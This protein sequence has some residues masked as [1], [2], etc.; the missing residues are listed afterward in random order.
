MSANMHRIALR[1]P[2]ITPDAKHKFGTT[3]P[4]A[5][6]LETASGKHKQENTAKS[7][8]APDALECTM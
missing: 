1:D 5:L 7:F 8:R 3:C 6:F 2:Q 4:D